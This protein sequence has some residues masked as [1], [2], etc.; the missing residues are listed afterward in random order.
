MDIHQL[1]R[2]ADRAV[3]KGDLDTVRIVSRYAITHA[4]LSESRTERLIADGMVDWLQT[5]MPTET[6]DNRGK[7]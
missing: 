2:T 3:Q 7:L 4:F 6:L 1:G 5:Y